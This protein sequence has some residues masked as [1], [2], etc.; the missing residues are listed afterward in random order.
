[1]KKKV[2]YGLLIAF[3]IICS[4]KLVSILKNKEYYTKLLDEKTNI[5]VYGISAPRGRILDCNGKVLVDNIGIKTI[6][7]NKIKGITKSK[8]LEIAGLLAN[9]L[10]VDEATIDELKEYYLINNNGGKYLITD[11]EYKLFE[12]RKITKEEIEIKK[13]ARI[14]DDMLNY[15]SK[16]K[17]QA[18][19][20]SLMNKGYIYSKKK[21]AS[22]LTEEEYAKIIES[23]IPGIT[24]E[25]SWD[26]IYLY[27][28]TLKN[29]F[30]RIGSITKETKEYYL[31][32][33]YELTDTVGISYLENVYEDYLRGKKAKY[34]VGSDYT[35]TLLEEEQKG[36]DLI[37]SID[38]DMQIK[39]EEIL[40]DK[41]ILAKK[42]GNTE[43]FKD[44]YALV[45]DPL[46]GSIKAISGI[47][48]NDDNTFSDISLNNIN[49]SY[50]IG[51]AVKGATIA[52]GY[53]YNLIEP[54][55]YINDSC[56]KLL[57][58]PKKCSF[59][60][61]GKVNDLTAL[62]NSSNYYQY[63]IAIKLTGNTYTPNMKLNATQE[64]FKKYREML[65]SFGLGV[66]TGID[67]PNEQ[68]GIMGKTIA[69]DLLLNLSIGQY[70][71]Y[72][73]IEVLQYIN[74]VATGKRIKLSL[75]QEI[76]SEEETLL[77]NKSEVLNNVDLDKESLN[78]IKEGMKLVLSEGTGKFYVPQGL[79]FAGK[80]GTS[81]SFLDTNNDNVVDT[82]TISSTFT[83]FYP[84]DNPKFS[85]VVITPNVSHKNGKTDAF[86]FGASKITKELVT[87]LSN[88]Y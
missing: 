21:I 80:T 5:Y 15:S 59:K 32:K 16:E 22:N 1:M 64:H 50:T 76:K 31:T 60:K 52:V 6:Y 58:V 2:I 37:L 70:D 57:F 45:S 77:E 29:I 66:K 56:V 30:G 34:K 79:N 46:T 25:L 48:L 55:K 82:A 33:D 62:S 38:I 14:T 28:D 73:P 67:L 72:T 17:T 20:Y 13:R 4:F 9:I 81:E 39:T 78:R 35:L 61:L 75:M 8:E 10:S 74:S 19:I 84:A 44:S 11:E 7:Y 42:Y 68:T 40:K 86:Y 47:R 41:L 85:I 27:G 51:S 65:S 43:Y 88:N 18:H 26:R 49:K 24:G 69:D 12:E 36:N 54:G 71:T 3:F 23:K 63:M 53:K 87:F 83:G